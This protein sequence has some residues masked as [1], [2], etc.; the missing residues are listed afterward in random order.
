MKIIANIGDADKRT[1]TDL[2][3]YSRFL[4]IRFHHNGIFIMVDAYLGIFII[5]LENCITFRM[6]LIGLSYWRYFASYIL[7]RMM[8]L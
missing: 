8:K 2:G 6:W 4:D 7:S 5:N 3:K 1:A